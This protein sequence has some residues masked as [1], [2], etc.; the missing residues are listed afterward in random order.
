MKNLTINGVTFKV[1]KPRS[2][3]PRR[4]ECG[5]D[6]ENAIYNCYDRPSV[7]KVGIWEDWRKWACETEGVTDFAI[8][9]YNCMQF[10]IHGFYTDG[11]HGYNIY[12][13][14]TRNELMQVY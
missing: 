7:Y 1:T 6:G 2:Y 11:E 9:S 14:K 4:C 10:T 13:T 12:I 8:G 5:F 3:T